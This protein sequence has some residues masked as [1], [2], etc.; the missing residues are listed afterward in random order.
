[1]KKWQRTIAAVL[2]VLILGAVAIPATVH[3]GGVPDDVYV[4]PGSK[5]MVI[6]MTIDVKII[7]IDDLEGEIDVAPQIKWDRTFLPISPIIHAIGGTIT[8]NAQKRMVTIVYG[9][10]TIVLTIGSRYALVNG[11]R[12]LIDSNP[13]LVPYIQAP[14]R[15]M[16]PVRFI[17]EQL[18]A[19]VRWNTLLQRVTLVFPLL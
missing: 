14:G 17:A 5:T 8:W 13:D 9:K 1:M 18:G 7:K 15:T 19:F 11:K 4:I 12:M 6:V 2:A 10:K 3:A 16:L